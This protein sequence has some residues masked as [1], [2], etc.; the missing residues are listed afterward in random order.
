[1]GAR[2]A[3]ALRDRA[4]SWQTTA[5]YRLAEHWF[6]VGDYARAEAAY[7]EV[8]NEIPDH[9]PSLFNL[10]VARIRLEAYESAL[11]TL[12]SLSDHGRKDTIPRRVD[13]AVAYNRALALQYLYRYD[14]A[15]RWST[16]LAKGVLV[17][18]APVRL[19]G[20]RARA[21]ELRSVGQMEGPSLMLHSS[22]SVAAGVAELDDAVD[23]A[24]TPREE[25]AG[26]L[27]GALE[28]DDGPDHDVRRRAALASELGERH[29]AK[30]LEWYVRLSVGEHARTRYNL[31]CHLAM[32]AERTPDRDQAGEL[33]VRAVEHAKVALR[34]H[35][36][37]TWAAKDPALESLEVEK[38]WPRALAAAAGRAP[39]AGAGAQQPTQGS[40]PGEPHAPERPQPGDVQA[41]PPEPEPEALH[42]LVS[43]A[44][45]LLEEVFAG[46]PGPALVG[47]PDRWAAAVEAIEPLVV[48]T[49]LIEAFA[50]LRDPTTVYVLPSPHRHMVA[51]L[52]FLLERCLDG[53]QERYVV[54]AVT[55]DAA[56]DLPRGAEVTKWNGIP[57]SAAVEAC[58]GTIAATDAEAR[59]ARAVG[60]LTHW[61]VDL[62]G[63]VALD[64]VTIGYDDDGQSR[65]AVVP[66][67]PVE[68][69][70]PSAIG[71]D[72]ARL[73]STDE[74]GMRVL[75]AQRDLL[76]GSD[77]T[78]SRTFPE[79]VQFTSRQGR[80]HLRIRSF[81]VGD[82]D[83]FAREVAD[84]LSG[85]PAEGVVIDVR[86][87]PGGQIAAAE[88]LIQLFIPQEVKPQALAVRAGDLTLRLAR[89]EGDLA[90]WREPIETAI[91]NGN[92]L[93]KPMQLAAGHDR[94]CNEIGQRYHGP[95]ILL[96]DARTAGAASFLEA[97][98]ARHRIGKVITTDPVPDRPRLSN[99]WS[100][101]LLVRL[102]PGPPLVRPAGDAAFSVSMRVASEGDEAGGWEHVRHV[103]TRRDVLAEDQ[104]LFA[105]AVGWLEEQPVRVLRADL[106]LVPGKHIH[107]TVT[108]R[109]I[110][111][112]ELYVDGNA[113][114]VA[115]PAGDGDHRVEVKVE[116]AGPYAVELRGLDDDR[117]IVA[118]RRVTIGGL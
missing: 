21:A 17:K 13:L 100:H 71:A 53:D 65:E 116:G 87:N 28:I 105:A 26:R 97:G 79:H 69:P 47:L 4:A 14:E 118:R 101:D 38:A 115:E 66:R 42:A 84:I 29:A 104:D 10:A 111:L 85:L 83:A 114:E 27:D 108:T 74:L 43:Q 98:F 18:R 95:V 117:T 33:R 61:P 37:V 112:L 96:V 99:A 16:R 76:S 70:S 15:V 1:M 32:L 40:A 93:T 52:P 113:A 3:E 82:A 56:R 9:G 94:A 24:L 39:A 86:G 11:M 92:R 5:A 67:K 45:V 89:S 102:L 50:A 106:E 54:A 22:V 63:P 72:T 81:E 80:G 19:R 75:A 48:H 109:Q 49:A 55:A 2:G 77:M 34:D 73:L 91:E 36:L 64:T 88:R 58:T 7:R 23:G 107:G 90:D 57:I 68:V 78:R 110:H 44:H 60:A 6:A 62:L 51:S 35:R 12:D 8:L 46:D 20:R 30:H 41:E 59:T 25:L 103:L 31:A